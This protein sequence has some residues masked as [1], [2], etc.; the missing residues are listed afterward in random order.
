M[1]APLRRHPIRVRP[2]LNVFNAPTQSFRRKHVIDVEG[3]IFV[4]VHVKGRGL[5]GAMDFR[6]ALVP[7]ALDAA[8][9]ECVEYRRQGRQLSLSILFVPDRVG[10]EVTRNNYVA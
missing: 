7:S 5:L 9:Q 10:V 3:L 2:D 6:A 8:I 1:V 4:Q